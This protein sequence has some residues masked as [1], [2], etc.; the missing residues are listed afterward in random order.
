MNAQNSMDLGVAE[1]AA[2]GLAVTSGLCLETGWNVRPHPD[3]LP[4]GEGESSAVSL[5]KLRRYLP[6]NH[7]PDQD[8]PSATFPL[9]GE[10][11]KGEGGCQK[12]TCFELVGTSSRFAAPKPWANVGNF[13]T[14]APRH[15]LF[16]SP[17]TNHRFY[18]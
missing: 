18:E 3:P 9:L 15:R 14:N 5:N 17:V 11:I 8:R 6:Y 1:R 10:R 16:L 12:Q 4:R 13:E 2:A 7:S